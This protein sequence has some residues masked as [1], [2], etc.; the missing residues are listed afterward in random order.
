MAI[1]L[2]TYHRLH[3]HNANYTFREAPTDTGNAFSLG[4][5]TGWNLKIYEA[6]EAD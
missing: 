1:R 2:G 6:Q 3:R 5:W 4:G